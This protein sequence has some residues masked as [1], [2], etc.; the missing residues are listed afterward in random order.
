LDPHDVGVGITQVVPVV[1]AVLAADSSVV[2]IEQPE[3]HLHPKCQAALGD[4]LIAGAV[5][6]EGSRNQ[7]IVETHSEHMI[8]RLLR[9]IRETTRGEATKDAHITPADI[10]ILYVAPGEGESSIIRMGVNDYHRWDGSHFKNLMIRNP[11]E[12]IGIE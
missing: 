10:S 7:L 1:V 9:R 4:V 6:S 11:V 8:L 12:A 3:L 5:S 2:A